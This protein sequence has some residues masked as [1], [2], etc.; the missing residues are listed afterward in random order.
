MAHFLTNIINIKNNISVVGDEVRAD[1]QLDRF[2][3]YYDDYKE[4]VENL[5]ENQ[6]HQDNWTD[7]VKMK[8]LYTNYNF[9]KKIV[10]LKTI[11]Y[12]KE[13]KRKYLIGTTPETEEEGSPEIDQFSDDYEAIVNDSNINTALQQTDL[14]ARINNISA[15]RIMLNIDNDGIQYSPVPSHEITIEQH[16]ED[17]LRIV[18]LIHTIKISDTPGDIRRMYFQWTTGESQT[19]TPIEKDGL[20]VGHYRIYNDDGELIEQENNKDDL[21]PYETKG[22]KF[23]IPYVFFRTVKSNEFWNETANQDIYDTTLQVNV[24]Y[25]H[26]NNMMKFFGYDQKF[27]I[28][29][30][31]ITALQGKR[32]DP[33]T[34]INIK[35]TEPNGSADIKGIP[36]SDRLTE[37]DKAIFVSISQTA[38]IHGV[39]LSADSMTAQRQTAEALTINRKS[40]IESREKLLPIYRDAENELAFKTIVIANTAIPNSGLGKNIPEDGT[41]QIDFAELDDPATPKE[42]AEVDVINIS[43]NLDNPVNIIM[44]SN[45]DLNEDQAREVWEKNKEINNNNA[46]T[47]SLTTP[48]QPGQGEEVEPLPDENPV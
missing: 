5:L 41:F 3:M 9:L 43:Q 36:L 18:G 32:T 30:I 37:L 24:N 20:R 8:L 35:P 29:D 28:G 22:G 2:N 46:R 25:T 40:L 44:G 7:I 13:A 27:I 33:T 47:L 6:F 39:S 23:I 1:S 42:K 10:D 19:D 14:Y 17:P 11:I 4:E 21:N 26:K 15:C 48:E 45:P 31:D 16:P 34:I 38:D 12:K